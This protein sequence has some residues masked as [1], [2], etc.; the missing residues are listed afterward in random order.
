MCIWR[1]EGEV[2]NAANSLVPL[3]NKYEAWRER[4]DAREERRRVT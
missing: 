4:D 3:K 1:R 2:G